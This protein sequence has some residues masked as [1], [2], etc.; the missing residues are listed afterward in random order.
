MHSWARCG[1]ARATTPGTKRAKV[2][3]HIKGK[4]VA[5]VGAVEV[6]PAVQQPHL[7]RGSLQGSACRV[8]L[9]S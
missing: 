7:S 4:L 6:G 2:A 1:T 5:C 8:V 3:M 9:Y